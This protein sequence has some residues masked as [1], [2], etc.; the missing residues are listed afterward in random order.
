MDD[1]KGD[2]AVLTGAPSPQRLER[3]ARALTIEMGGTAG[4]AM[5]P[6]TARQLRRTAIPRT[7]TVA[8]EVGD[9]VR[10]ARRRLADPVEALLEATGGSLLFSGKI[11]DVERRTTTGF[12]RGSVTMRG[13]GSYGSEM[14]VDFQNENLVARV[15]DHAVAMVPDLICIVASD[16]AE[17][18][19]TEMLRYGQR[20]AV[21]GIPCHPRLST[22]EALAV[23]GPR[24]F[25]YN[26]DFVPL[27]PSGVLPWTT[28]TE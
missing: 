18:I 11:T 3:L 7:L 27:Q 9:T 2:E 23:I 10:A 5:A 28:F 20:V 15:D 6:M 19:T 25:G 22:S 21:I 14:H 17:P 8:R 24:A 1:D 4:M 26:L 16:D 12:A 13:T